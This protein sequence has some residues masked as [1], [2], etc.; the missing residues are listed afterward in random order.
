MGDTG[1]DIISIPKDANRAVEV[2]QKL[3][4][5]VGVPP[6]W[7]LNRGT[8]WRPPGTRKWPEV[9]V[10]EHT[11]EMMRQGFVILRYKD[12][13]QVSVG[14][15]ELYKGHAILPGD[16]TEKWVVCKKGERNVRGQEHE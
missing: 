3:T 9:A 1:T 12:K 6:F 15:D 14:T 4:Q 10:M 16:I 2:I 5:K 7:R 11:D 13:T 8:L